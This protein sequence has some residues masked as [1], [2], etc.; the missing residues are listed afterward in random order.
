MPD[1]LLVA[2][3][4]EPAHGVRAGPGAVALQD[5]RRVEFRVGRQRQK[6]HRLIGRHGG[7]NLAHQSGHPGA[8]PWTTREDDVR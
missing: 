2:G 3:E 7:L 5:R 4:K 6:F 8:R 1:L